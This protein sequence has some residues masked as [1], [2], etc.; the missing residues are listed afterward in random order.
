MNRRLLKNGLVIN[1]DGQ[2]CEDIHI[3]NGKII[4]VGNRFNFWIEI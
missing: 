3:E 2:K 1:D 4:A